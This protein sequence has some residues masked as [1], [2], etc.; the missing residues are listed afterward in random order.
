MRVVFAASEAAPFCKTGGLADVAGALPRALASAGHEVSLFLP[1]YRTVR[2]RWPGRLAAKL[3]FPFGA[4]E[5]RADLL[6]ADA[7]GPAVFFVDCPV[8]FD[9]EG[10]YQAGAKDHPGNGE[11]FAFFCRAVIEGA[12]ACVEGVQVFHC[13]DWQSALIPAFLRTLYRAEPVARAATVLT[14]H[15]A[16]Y[17]GLF[18]RTL[19]R[20]SGLPEEQFTPEWLEY[21]GQL[22]FLKAGLVYAEKINAVSPSYAR[23]VQGSAEFGRGLEGVFRGRRDDLSGIL[24]GL[25][26][27]AWDPS[28]DPHLARRY[29]AQDAAEGKTA[30]RKALLKECGL[31]AGRGPLVAIVSRLDPQKGLDLALEALPPLLERGWRLAV[32]GQGEDSLARRLR[33]L[34]LE[35]PKAVHFRETFDEPFAHR[36]YAACDLFLMPSRFEPCGLGQ[37]IAMR[38]GGV[39][40]GV[41]TG[42]LADTLTEGGPRANG[43]LAPKPEAAALLAALGRAFAAFSDKDAWSKLRESCMLYDSS[44]TRSAG[45]YADLYKAAVERLG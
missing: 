39:P 37:L 32:L 12:K 15:N 25:D 4:G 10:L 35:N 19:A 11:R 17:Q 36:L 3:S 14:V 31:S 20:A 44:W 41:K 6:R 26:G 30:C 42:G 29:G 8:F 2:S 16:A 43:F 21:Y 5:G 22:N 40:V 9:W 28:R 45:L 34:A 18:P 24:N 13:H 7:P 27:D 38:Y 23:E 33:A 1:Y